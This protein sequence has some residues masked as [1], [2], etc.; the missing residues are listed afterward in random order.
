[1]KLHADRGHAST[2]LFKR[3]FADSDME[4]GDSANFAHEA[5][6]PC[7]I[8]PASDKEPHIPIAGT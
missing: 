1:M 4:T 5:L 3:V 7:E 8:C 6:G 2:H